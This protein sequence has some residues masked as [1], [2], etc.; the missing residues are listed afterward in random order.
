MNVTFLTD[1]DKETIDEDLSNLSKSLADNHYN[2]EAFDE[3]YENYVTEVAE[4][5]GGDA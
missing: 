2:K 1:K 5:I 4:L 3:M